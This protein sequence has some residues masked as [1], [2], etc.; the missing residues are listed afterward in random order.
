MRKEKKKGEKDTGHSAG[1]SN[2]D[3]RFRGGRKR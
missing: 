1:G 3:T 2:A